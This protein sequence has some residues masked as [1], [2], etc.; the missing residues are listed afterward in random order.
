[1]NDEMT[2]KQGTNTFNL[3]FDLRER[4]ESTSQAGRK[5]VESKSKASCKLACKMDDEDEIVV[6]CTAVVVCS[7]V[8]AMIAAKS[9]KRKHSTWVKQYIG[10]YYTSTILPEMKANDVSRYVQ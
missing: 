2:P 7:L 4:V 8:A 6:A 1:M 10:L 5:H 3:A 9:K